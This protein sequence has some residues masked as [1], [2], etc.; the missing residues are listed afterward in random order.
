[1][2]ITI[3]QACDDAQLFAPAFKG[4]PESWAAWRTVLRA[5]FGV[6]LSDAELPLFHEIAGGRQPPSEPVQEA[7]LICGRRGGKSF[8]AALIAVYLAT[9]RDYRP[10]LAPGEVATVGLLAVDKK[11]ARSLLRYVRGHFDRPLFRNMVVRENPEGLE[12]KNRVVIEV[13][14]TS[15]R[16]TRG[17]TYAGVVLDEL[18]FWRSEESAAPDVEIVNALRPGLAS[19]PGAPLIGIGSPYRRGGL[20]FD[21]YERHYGKGSDTLVIRA[22]SRTMNPTLSERIVTRAFDEDPVLA[23]AEYGAEFRGDIAAAFDEDWI[24]RALV[25]DGD[26]P[27]RERVTYFAFADPSGGKSD[28]YTLAIGHKEGRRLVIDA[29]RSRRPPFDPVQVTSEFALLC[30]TYGVRTVRG[31][32]YAATWNEREWRECGVR[33]RPSESSKSEIYLEAIPQF[34]SGLIE[35]PRNKRLIEELRSLERRTSRSGRDTIDHRTGQHDDVANAVCGCLW[36][37]SP[38]R[39]IGEP[40]IRVLGDDRQLVPRHLMSTG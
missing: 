34:S 16:S 21:V 19:I 26:L 6:P 17:Y 32:R 14:A 10:F 20:L 37:M 7:F 12:L 8:I 18:A 24:Q 2:K 11:Q 30:H 25:H 28:A 15:F 27:P 38:R 23:A 5:L 9:M 4:D 1:M 36:A 40:R 3:D 35:L 29:I 31:D 22:P 39:V 13:T 33:Y